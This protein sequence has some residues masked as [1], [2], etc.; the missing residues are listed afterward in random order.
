[1]SQSS[2]IPHIDR[3]YSLSEGLGS[4]NKRGTLL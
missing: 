2:D 3:L 4:G 1:M